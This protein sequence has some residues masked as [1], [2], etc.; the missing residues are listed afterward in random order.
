MEPMG[1]DLCATAQFSVRSQRLLAFFLEYAS[2]S[3]K[4]LP[5][6]STTD[7]YFKAFGPKTILFMAFGLF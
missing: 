6:G 1:S 7:S 5:L 2:T 4:L 3:T